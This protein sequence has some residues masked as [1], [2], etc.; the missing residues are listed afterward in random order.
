LSFTF[1]HLGQAFWALLRADL[2]NDGIEDVLV[3][4]YKWA[5]EGTFAVGDVLVLTRRAP[6]EGFQIVEGI[7]LLPKP[8]QNS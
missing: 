1:S 2:N 4:T 5:T 3:S 7:D 6:D 8:P